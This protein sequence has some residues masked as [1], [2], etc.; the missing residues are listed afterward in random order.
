MKNI[1]IICALFPSLVWAQWR[2]TPDPQCIEPKT[3]EDQA[4]KAE[5]EYQ[6]LKKAFQKEEGN[7]TDVPGIVF[8]ET[9]EI[10]VIEYSPRFRK[11]YRLSPKLRI[12]DKHFSVFPQRFQDTFFQY[13][14]VLP[15]IDEIYR[16]TDTL[17]YHKCLLDEF[18]DQVNGIMDYHEEILTNT[19]PLAIQPLRTS[20]TLRL[21]SDGYKDITEK[22]Y[23]ELSLQNQRVCKDLETQKKEGLIDILKHAR[24]FLK[25]QDEADISFENYSMQYGHANEPLP[26]PFWHSA[27][28]KKALARSNAYFRN[29][30]LYNFY[31]LLEDKLPLPLFHF[32]RAKFWGDLKPTKFLENPIAWLFSGVEKFENEG[33]TTKEEI[34]FVARTMEQDFRSRHEKWRRDRNY[35]IDR[36]KHLTGIRTDGFAK[37]LEY[38]FQT[39]LEINAQLT[40]T[41]LYKDVVCASQA[42]VVSCEE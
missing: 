19:L 28:F 39:L 35:L 32:P 8:H 17:A 25:H 41:L 33:E 11:F 42:E 36:G 24:D 22:L 31:Y 15:K 40:E 34:F 14:A 23:A 1:L 30:D 16:K 38:T 3:L 5:F 29:D 6:Q 4:L 27:E 37:E 12:I 26:S 18:Y 10:D 21:T 20:K 13:M 2:T 7:C 9:N